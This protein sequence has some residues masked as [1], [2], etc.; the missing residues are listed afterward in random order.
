MATRLSDPLRNAAA[1]ASVSGMTTVQFYTGTQPTNA[2]D[3]ATGTLLG[4]ITLPGSPFAA[5][6]G[7]VAAKAGT[8]SGS[9]ATS[10]TPGY[11]RISNG[12][13]KRFDVNIT[14]SAGGGDLTFDSVTWV[15]GGTIT[16]NTFTFT[17]PAS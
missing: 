8:W 16:I 14:I 6:S 12:S 2:G 9:V 1:D 13:T 17:V 3:A 15:S 7:G 11:A 5:A 4:T 10:G